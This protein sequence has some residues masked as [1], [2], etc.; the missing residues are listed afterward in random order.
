V[1]E[2]LETMRARFGALTAK[3]RSYQEALGVLHWDLRTGAPPRAVSTRSETIGML[4]AECLRLSV[5]EEM[6]ELLAFF[7]QPDVWPLL[8]EVE[9]ASIRECRREYDRNRRIPPETYRA[10]VALT[11]EAESVVG[12]R[13]KKPRISRFFCLI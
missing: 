5:S 11:A 12:G 9:R 8:H 10:F 7:E 1:A 2:T 4:S 13:R 6:G 3:I